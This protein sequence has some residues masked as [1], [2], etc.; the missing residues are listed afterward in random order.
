[1]VK[2]THGKTVTI[3][4]KAEIFDLRIIVQLLNHVMIMDYVFLLFCFKEVPTP[5][6]SMIY[7]SL[8]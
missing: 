5:A 1:M 2:A 7:L 4:Q 3:S 8:N 6:S